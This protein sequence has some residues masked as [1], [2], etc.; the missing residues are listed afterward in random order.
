MYTFHI[1]RMKE[2]IYV[3]IPH[4]ENEERRAR[5]ASGGYICGQSF[6]AARQIYSTCPICFRRSRTRG[7]Y[8]GESNRPDF[9]TPGTCRARPRVTNS[10]CTYSRTRYTYSR[11]RDI[12][13]TIFPPSLTPSLPPSL[14][15][16][17]SLTHL[18]L[19]RSL[20]LS[21]S[22]APSLSLFPPLS[23]T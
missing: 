3:Y 4:Y 11:T 17:H 22:L 14:Y 20:S 23:H 13:V 19:C 12:R 21:L 15:F 2:G 16:S 1:K 7:I 18:A 10:R 5:A 8:T 6:H 9:L